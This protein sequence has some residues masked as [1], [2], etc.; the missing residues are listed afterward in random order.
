MI[1]VI[2]A[3]DADADGEISAQEIENAAAALKKL[4]KNKDGKLT[5]DELRPEMP[6]GGRFG[7]FGA[8][9]PGGFGPR[10]G[11]GGRGGPG[12][13]GPPSGRPGGPPP[14]RAGASR[15]EEFLNRLKG[16]DKNNDGKVSRDELPEGMRRL[17]DIADEN[18][19]DAIDEAEAKKAVEKRLRGAAARRGGDRGQSGRR[20]GGERPERPKRPARPSDDG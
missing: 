18:D 11:F 15:A 20:P 7:G 6:P 13:G 1:P 3:L 9:G 17:L 5:F 19:D 10:G 16:F 2:K 4:D 8:G 14:E 12:A